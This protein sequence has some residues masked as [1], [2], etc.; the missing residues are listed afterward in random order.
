MLGYTSSGSC[1]QAVYCS[2]RTRS[3][4]CV[5]VCYGQGHCREEQEV[6]GV[7]DP[8]IL[9]VSQF[10]IGFLPLDVRVLI[11]LSFLIS[12]YSYFICFAFISLRRKYSKMILN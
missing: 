2:G 6:L 5:C 12:F 9:Y 11:V 10:F 3:R 7:C 8:Y 4:V 1:Y